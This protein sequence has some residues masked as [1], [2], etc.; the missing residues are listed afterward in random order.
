MVMEYVSFEGFC[1]DGCCF[2]E[3]CYLYVFVGVVFFVDG[4]VFFY[5]G[6]IKVMVVVYGFYEVFNKVY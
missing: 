1:F 4:F 3:M 6:N 2:Y 5:M